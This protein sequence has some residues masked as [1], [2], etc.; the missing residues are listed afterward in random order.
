[1]ESNFAGRDHIW[2]PIDE[3]DQLMLPWASY[4]P[5]PAYGYVIQI[6]R[7]IPFEVLIKSN[8]FHP[9]KC[10]GRANY[11]FR[12]IALLAALLWDKMELC[13]NQNRMKFQFNQSE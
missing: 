4:N 8:L 10:G 1:M 13:D 2:Q 7:S 9:E 3:I 6:F 12:G 5:F 11:A